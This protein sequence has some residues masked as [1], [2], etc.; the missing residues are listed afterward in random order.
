MPDASPDPALRMAIRVFTTRPPDEHPEEWP[1]KGRPKRRYPSEA[2]IF[3]TETT[4]GPS[5][6]LKVGVWRLYIDRFRAEPG[7]TC[8]E[9]GLFYADDLPASDPDGYAELRRYWKTRSDADVASG[10]PSRLRLMSSSEWLQ[11]RLFR[12]GVQHRNRCRVVGFNLGFD[13]GQLASYWGEARGA[14]RGG[15]SIGLWG[16]FDSDDAWHDLRFHPRL[17]M[18][19]LDPRRTLFAWGTLNKQDADLVSPAPGQFVDLHTLVF[20]LTDENHS[21]ETACTAFGDPFEKAGVEYGVVDEASLDYAR[22]DVRHTAFLYRSCLAEL[23]RHPGVELDPARLF[24]PATV[25]VRYL[26]AIGVAPPLDRFVADAST[27]TNRELMV[28]DR[29]HPKVVGWA[30]GG[31]FGGRAEARLIRTPVPVTVVDAT[32][33]Y[34]TVNANL[35]TWDLLTADR[36]EV[37]DATEAVRAL[38]ASPAL[39]DRVLDRQ[40][41][42]EAIGVTLVELDHPAGDILPVRAFYDPAG[43]DP[44]IGV[45]PLTYAGRLWYLLPDVIAST[46]LTGSPPTVVRALRLIGIGRQPDLHR[47]RLRGT[48]LI[49]PYSEDPFAAMVVE[50]QR[51]K[52][53]QRLSEVERKR[54]D[55]FLKITA[56]ATAYG[57]LARFDRREL[58]SKV[59]ITVWGPDEQPIPWTTLNPEDP[60]PYTFPPIA[61]TITAAARL[62]LAILEQEVNDA[63]GTYVFCDTDSMAVVARPQ[64]GTVACPPHDGANRVRA[65][66]SAAVEAILAKFTNLN[67]YPS[68]LGIPVWKVEHDSLDRPLTCYS[69]SAKRYLLYRGTELV[70]AVDDPDGSDELLADVPDLTGWSEHG[71]GMYLAPEVDRRGRPLRDTSGRRTW[72]GTAWRWVIDDALN[73]FP[74]AP[75][76]AGFPAL[77]R[78]TVSSPAI[79]NWFRGRDRSLGW[80]DRMR[81]G[82]FGVLAHPIESEEAGRMPASA[83]E[84]RPERWPNLDWYDRHTGHEIR[85]TTVDPHEEPERFATE[86]AS[87]AVRVRTLG[88]ALARYR[89]RPEHKSLG[90]DG[91]PATRDTRGLLARRPVSSDPTETLLIGKEGNKLL[92]REIGEEYDPRSYRAEFG[93]RQDQWASLVVPMLRRM[94]AIELIR[95][96]DPSW[97]RSIERSLADGHR[98]RSEE[99]MRVLSD[100]ALTHARTE[101]GADSSADITGVMRAFLAQAGE[102]RLCACECGT[103]VQSPRARWFNEAHRKR[104]SRRQSLR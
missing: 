75:G 100:L 24:S 82:S 85:V 13:L 10:F 14:Y 6:Q 45:N 22:D 69:I 91:A 26:T 83:Y 35:R 23:R 76:W 63:G 56:N 86:L 93:M 37:G 77:T 31:F 78:F 20:A 7:V 98:P 8:V 73:R 41:W 9:E 90:P 44:G 46:L 43:R 92:E 51:I 97:R 61:A 15:F 66:D 104:A 28:G 57:V 72:L 89:G 39:R 27:A 2:L 84:P 54:L 30:T 50:R 19:A 40:T 12:Y 80:R 47:V 58:T 21:L 3:D 74:K 17:L 49:D 88:E 59:A 79:A 68:P 52:T 55:R 103:P 60:G 11:K 38:L 29:L 62:M 1:P 34:P 42:S 64:G 81:P 36:L 95:L 87:G 48:R 67:P 25:G 5:Q 102:P 70:A 101:V 53:D 4:T 94:G 33:M 71:L 65:L 18:K 32:S 96:T 16:E 99:R